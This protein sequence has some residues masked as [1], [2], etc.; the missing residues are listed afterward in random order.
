[1]ALDV[2]AV[3]IFQ[4][5]LLIAVGLFFHLP[6]QKNEIKAIILIPRLAIRSNNLILRSRLHRIRLK[7]FEQ[8]IC[9]SFLQTMIDIIAKVCPTY[10]TN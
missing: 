3:T 6:C 7:F 10:T 9:S 2:N 1:M 4:E 8:C 5:E